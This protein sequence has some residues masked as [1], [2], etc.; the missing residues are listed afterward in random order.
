MDLNINEIKSLVQL[1]PFTRYKYFIKRVADNGVLYTLMV[2]NEG[3]A[4]S[5]LDNYLLLPVWSSQEYAEMCKKG[6]WSN[7]II[8]QLSL[9]DLEN[10]IFD[11]VANNNY[12]FNVFPV[13]DKTGF[14]VDIDEF[15]R[16][17]NEELENY[18][19][20]TFK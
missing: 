20:R 3:Y 10:E 11:L 8:K 5:E 17:L 19:Y 9:Q 1:E 16:D 13:E 4:I 2:D 12:L 15:V 7:Y 14:V 18:L 6:M